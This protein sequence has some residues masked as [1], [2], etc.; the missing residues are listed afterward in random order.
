MRKKVVE[1]IKNQFLNYTIEY[2][3][4]G[5]V[6]F[7]AFFYQLG[8][9]DIKTWDEGVY[10]SNVLEMLHRKEFL[11]KYFD[12][13]PEMWAVI[14]PLIAWFQAASLVIFGISEFAFRIPSAIS[15]IIIAI[16]IFYFLYKEFNERYWGLFAAIILAL[17]K[18]FV[19]SHVARTGD[20][21]VFVSMF[22]TLYILSFYKFYK[23]DFT[24]NRWAFL[25]ILF[26]F[27]SFW[28]KLVAG[29]FYLPVLFFFILFSGKAKNFFRNKRVYLYTITFLIV[30]I[31]YYVYMEFKVPGYT[32]TAL[33]NGIIGRFTGNLQDNHLEPFWYY[34]NNI[35]SYN[36]VPWLYFLPLSLLLLFF[37]SDKEKRKFLIFLCSAVL[38]YWFVIS[39]SANKL[40]WYDAQL[41]PLL[42]IITAYSFKIIFNIMVSYLNVNLLKKQLFFL[43]FFI[44][45]FYKPT[46]EIE[47]K[48]I[49]ERKLVAEEYYGKALKEVAKSYP[50]ITSIYILHPYWSPHVIYYK[51]LYNLYHNYNISDVVIENDIPIFPESYILYNHPAVKSKLDTAYNYDILL[52]FNEVKFVHVKN[53]K[54][55][56]SL[57]YFLDADSM[58]INSSEYST[59]YNT[60]GNTSIRLNQNNLYSN[61]FDFSFLDL[62]VENISKSHINADVLMKK[63]L[64]DAFF[65]CET[66]LFKIWDG[67]NLNNYSKIHNKWYKLDTILPL[68]IVKN[69][70]KLVVKFY[71]WNKNINN[72]VNV[73]S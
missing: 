62:K 6:L 35:K 4:L 2:I 59:K 7:L 57:N 33:H 30:T 53:Q 19:T 1:G 45:F 29:F 60:T 15:A 40:S 56:L 52:E 28:T 61:S 12:G 9:S 25:F 22:S 17:S 18:G 34:W 41:Y 31:A 36:Y 65:V 8:A 47:R 10:A 69:E 58:D 27:C 37:E 46:Y 39:L 50:D 63:N 66:P 71:F 67:I 11:V 26:V 64:F 49:S 72:N 42:A 55:N 20:L 68:P 14:P 73:N 16:S 38:F 21:D 70:Q 13:L 3:I 43:V 54:T 5:I 23:S 51:T 44:A 32:T 48:N 24:N